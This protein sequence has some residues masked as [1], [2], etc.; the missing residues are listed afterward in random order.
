MLRIVVH[1]RIAGANG[2]PGKS[3]CIGPKISVQIIVVRLR[4]SGEKSGEG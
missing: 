1:F 2:S 4:M 3:E